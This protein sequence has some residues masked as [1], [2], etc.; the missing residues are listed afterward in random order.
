MR[1]V[2]RGARGLATLFGMA[3]LASMGCGEVPGVGENTQ[4]EVQQA[5]A[6]VDCLSSLQPEREWLIQDGAVLKD[7][8]RTAWSGTLPREHAAADGAWSFGR[9]MAEMSGEV[10]AARFVRDWFER[11]AGWD[12]ATRALVPQLLAAWP[13]LEDGS[14]DLTKAPLRLK[15]IVNHL[16]VGEGHLVFGGVDANGKPLNLTVALA[17]VLPTSTRR[18]ALQWARQWH[19]VTALKP[20]SEDFNAALQSL[21]DHF[22]ASAG[23]ALVPGAK[24][25]TDTQR[26]ATNLGSVLCMDSSAPGVTLLSPA[27]GSFLRGTVS[28]TASAFDDVG[29]TRVDFFSGTTLIA[30]DTQPPFIVNWDTTTG[31]SGTTSLTAQAFD[32]DGNS[33]T[34]APVGVLVDNFVPIILGSSPRYNPQS[35]NYVRGLLTASWT[36]TDQGLSGIALTEFFEDGL[37]MGT[38]PGHSDL[39]YRFSWDTRRLGNRPYTL[40]L[41]ATDNAGNVQTHTGTW[42][43]DNSPPSSVL[44]APANGSVVSGVVT[45]SANAS[46]SQLLQYVAFE[47]DGVLQTPFISSAPFTRTW[48]TTGKSG[49]HVIVAVAYDRVGNSQR[50]N[51]VTVTVP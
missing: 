7:P 8:V 37:L 6:P 21:T 42:I 34:S 27:D 4:T 38:Q 26:V 15:A 25:S 13:R 10:P 30:S 43:V 18:E 31:P 19:D 29:V 5:R 1:I 48:D 2:S 11:G 44:T 23:R 35:L 22:T 28:V 17:Y 39:T 32:A 20:G 14:L 16:G 12:D 36:V 45:L 40:T 46:D 9:R 33:G 49:T 51:A 41:R 50:S 47:I 3:A 24:D